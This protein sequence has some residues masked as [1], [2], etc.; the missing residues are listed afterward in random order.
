MA[1]LPSR[2]HADGIQAS[3]KWR[4]EEQDGLLTKNGHHCEHATE[5]VSLA[6]LKFGERIAP[7]LA[8]NGHFSVGEFH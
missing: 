4:Q 7:A 5:K 6:L 2:S 1:D 3:Q 8:E